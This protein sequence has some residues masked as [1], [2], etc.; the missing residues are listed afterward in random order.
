MSATMTT[1]TPSTLAF[2][3]A[4]TQN[5]APVHEYR[6]MFSHDV[7]KKQKKWH[8]GSVRFHTFNKRVMVYDETKNFIGDLHYRDGGQFGEGTEI[9]LDR[10]VL[11]QV[12]DRIGQ[13]ETDLTPLLERRHAADESQPAKSAIRSSIARAYENPK[14]LAALLGPSQGP[15]GRSRLP[16]RSPFEQRQIQVPLAPEPVQQP[17]K[18]RRLSD[19][20]ENSVTTTVAAVKYGPTGRNAHLYRQPRGRRKSADQE[21]ES[22]QATQVVDLSRDDD[23]GARRPQRPTSPRTSRSR[24]SEEIVSSNDDRV[25]DH[26]PTVHKSGGKR[27]TRPQMAASKSASKSTSKLIP[28]KPKP[29]SGPRALLQFSAAPIR[30]KLL[31]RPLLPGSNKMSERSPGEEA[32]ACATVHDIDDLIE[33]GDAEEALRQFPDPS[34]ADP[35][36]YHSF[37]ASDLVLSQCRATPGPANDSSE[38]SIH[39]PKSLEPHPSTQ[40]T[41]PDIV[42]SPE[43]AINT[44]L[45]S[46]QR[47]R[48]S[49]EEMAVLQDS[50][51]AAPAPP[52]APPQPVTNDSFAARPFRRVVSEDDGVTGVQ[53]HSVDHAAIPSA[54]QSL[55]PIQGRRTL[56][57]AFKAPSRPARA[58]S[59]MDAPVIAAPLRVTSGANVVLKPSKD[60]SGPWTETE[61]YMLFEWWPPNRQKPSFNAT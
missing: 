41:F 2:N 36:Q 57:S 24:H 25:K 43:S 45:T 59:D 23:A 34:H 46:P 37:P 28:S 4:P 50:P 53:D 35:S 20:K 56:R 13:T 14:S 10:G 52:Q 30:R 48:P 39:G 60:E 54:L 49:V 42:S 15:L 55:N 5:T 40:E 26:T 11:V 31:Y 51:K 16:H 47:D 21:V 27:T 8:D 38:E 33:A 29:P 44:L 6:C 1:T 12:E 22:L 32:A 9:Q 7:R 17:S 58:L 61:A 3:I 18:R 19:D